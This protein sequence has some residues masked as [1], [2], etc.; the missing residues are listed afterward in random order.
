MTERQA[1]SPSPN[2][3]GIVTNRQL[4]LEGQHPVEVA[5]IARGGDWS[6]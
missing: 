3:L 5:A 1:L 6:E 2:T 4:F